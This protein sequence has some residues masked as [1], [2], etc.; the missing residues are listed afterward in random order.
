MDRKALPWSPDYERSFVFRSY[1]GKIILSEN[2]PWEFVTRE[3]KRAFTKTI[4]VVG[5][6]NIKMIY[7]YWYFH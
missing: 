4:T 3:C 1:L 6:V 7:Q 2:E 5:W